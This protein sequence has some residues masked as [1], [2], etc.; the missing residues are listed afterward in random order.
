MKLNL[1]RAAVSAQIAPLIDKFRRY[2]VFIFIVTFLGVYGF[3][4]LQVSS[5]TQ[6]EPTAAELNESLGTVKRL[7]LDQ[8]S[9]DK[10]EELEEQNIEV[11]T[12]FQQARDNP[13][14]E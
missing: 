12:L 13:F 11:Q 4:I 6:S 7:K 14:T 3:L 8:E 2:N 9:I 5:L 1:N 10:L